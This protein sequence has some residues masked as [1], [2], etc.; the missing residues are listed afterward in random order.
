[1]ARRYDH[2]WL[3]SYF[4]VFLLQAVIAWIVS[5]PIYFG[6]VSLAPASLTMLD[7]LGVLLFVSGM[8][9]EA[10]GDEQLRRFRAERV[11]RGKVLDTGLWRCTRHPNYFGEALVWWGFGLIG[12][13]TGGVPGLLGPAI[14]TSV[15]VSGVVLPNRRRSR[16]PDTSAVGRTPAFLAPAAGAGAAD[17]KAARFQKTQPAPKRRY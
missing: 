14:L 15:T 17:D 9:F 13:A 10:V 2:W 3:V 5:L 7:Y 1:V 6:I 4:K 16:R 12:A 11:N 8:V